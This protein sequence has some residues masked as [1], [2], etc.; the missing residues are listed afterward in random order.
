MNTV[1]DTLKGSTLMTTGISGNFHFDFKQSVSPRKTAVWVSQLKI[2]CLRFAHKAV[3]YS[4]KS[5]T[6]CK[7]FGLQSLG[8]TKGQEK[9]FKVKRNFEVPKFFWSA[10]ESTTSKQLLKMI[11]S[12]LL[13]ILVYYFLLSMD[14]A[15]V[16]KMIK[17]S[18]T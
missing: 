16:T 8:W 13:M 2:Q 6:Y 9:D 5:S 17:Y 7:H 15:L 11:L 1:T 10:Q 18:S 14:F 12:L 4:K 3:L